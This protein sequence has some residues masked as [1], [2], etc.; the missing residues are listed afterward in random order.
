M[1][2]KKKKR[3]PD[4]ALVGAGRWGKNLGRNFFE[5]GALHTLCDT[6][7]ALLD[8]YAEKYPGVHLTTNYKS[9]LE[10]PAVTRVVIAAP[11]LL[12]YRLAL[13]A[14][15]AGKDVYVEKPL[16]LD[17]GEAAELIEIANRG[18]RILMVGH[19]L[20]YHPHVRRLQEIVGSGELG[21]LQYIVSN[22]LNLGAIRTEENALW[23]FAPHDVSVILSLCGHHLPQQVRCMGAAYVSPGV[24]DVTLTILRFEGEIRAHIYVSWLNPFKEQKLITVGSSAMAVFDDT[25][26]W[27][28]KLL[29]YRNHLT[30]AQGTIPLINN[31]V[32]E[33]VVL[34]FEE[35]LR[36]ECEHFLHCC[37]ERI[38][39]RTDGQEG[40]RVLK[41]LQ[42][43]QSSLNTDGEPQD[44]RSIV[45]AASVKP[46]QYF[47]H[48]TAVVDSQA[49]I[50]PGAK[51]WHFSHIMDGA[52][53]GAACNIGQ[54]VVVS[55]GVILGKNVK[56]QNNV[57]IYTGVVCEDDVFL[58]PS[59]VFTNIKNPRSAVSRKNCFT[60]TRVRKG[61][62]IGANATILTGIELGQYSFVG[63]GAV[64]TKSVK[65]YA[66]V[67]GNPARQVGW[68]SRYGEKINLPLQA[69]K[70]EVL[71][72]ACPG[73]GEL[74]QLVG[75]TLSLVESQEMADKHA[76]EALSN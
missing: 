25:K 74:Y 33:K 69:P 72:A 18:K 71:T 54:N 13:E 75:S 31:C 26:P 55:P 52:K 8:E 66:L 12:H 28:E 22:R 53:V 7:E 62:T 5:L 30:W 61:T 70:G 36:M 6:N 49:D 48:P 41:V 59:M 16:C 40:M 3:T 68:M 63:A 58:G 14:L 24:A 65:P 20:Q 11:A 21:K 37:D 15:L 2:G 50:G 76:L 60:E 64:V 27:D 39:P 29:L 19:L 56:V 34:P 73:T 47:A 51:I 57:S 42:A 35:P 17:C 23:N 45:G 32:P 9:L 46:V 4:T 43:A 1:T 10:N 38:Q 67:A 44:P